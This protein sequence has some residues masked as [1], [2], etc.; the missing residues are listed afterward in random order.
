[1]MLL[2][3][4]IIDLSPSLTLVK[5]PVRS[6]SPEVSLLSPVLPPSFSLPPLPASPP[7]VE[8]FEK[9]FHLNY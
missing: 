8:D 6:V 5:K 2:K 9:K 7:D 4:S 3:N 1:M